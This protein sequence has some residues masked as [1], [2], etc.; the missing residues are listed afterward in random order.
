MIVALYYVKQFVFITETC[1][2]VFESGT[3]ILNELFV[4]ASCYKGPIQK[5]LMVIGIYLAY[6]HMFILRL[7]Y[8]VYITRNMYFLKHVTFILLYLRMIS[9][10]EHE[11]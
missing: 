7:L 6:L 9:H 3:V 8:K 10:N 4:S 5:N 11:S 1:T 2:V